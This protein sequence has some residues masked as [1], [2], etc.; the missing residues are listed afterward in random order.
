MVIGLVLLAGMAQAA[1][2][3]ITC[4]NTNPI[5]NSAGGSLAAGYVQIVRS[6]DGAVSL[7]SQATGA[8]LS[9]TDTVISSGTV[10]NGQFSA[11]GI[12]IATGQYVYIV[13]WDTWN[14]VG[15]PSGN[16]GISAISPAMTGVLYTYRPASFRVDDP[17][18]PVLQPDLAVSSNNITV[19]YV[20][21]AANPT[22]TF[23]VRNAG[24]GTMNWTA[25]E[26]TAWITNVNPAS[27]ANAAGVTST[28]TVTIDPAQ[29]N[30]GAVG[31]YAGPI[32]VTGTTAGTLHSPQ[33]VTIT[34][35]IT[36]APNTA[37]NTPT[38]PNPANNA[39]GI[40]A[41]QTLTWTGGDPDAGDTVNYDIVVARDAGLTDVFASTN[42]L[43][44]AS[45]ALTNMDR[46]LYYWR[47]TAEDNHGSRTVGPVWSFRVGNIAAHGILDRFEGTYVGTG[48]DG[49][50]GD[51]NDDYYLMPAGA[52]P[53]LTLS[54]DVPAGAADASSVAI[55]YPESAEEW[56]GYGAIVNEVSNISAYPYI[57][58]WMKGDGSAGTVKFQVRDEDGDNFTV[59]DA[60]AVP[61]SDTSWR[62]YVVNAA[63]L[64]ER[65]G[66]D[67]NGTLDLG[68]I[69]QY[70]FSFSG[71]AASTGT[72]YIDNVE[73]TTELPP[74]TIAVNPAA[75]TFTAEG[76]DP[77]D[78]TLNITNAG[79][80][81][82]VWTISS[83]Q[84][85]LT[86]TP[87]SG[88]NVG[89]V[90]VS[91][92]IT[93]LA[94]GTHNA[95]L[96]IT[97]DGATNSPLTVPVTLTVG[98]APTERMIDDFEGAE[99]TAGAD[100][101]WGEE[102]GDDGYYIDTDPDAAGAALILR[103]VTDDVKSGAHAAGI[104]M[105]AADSAAVVA[106]DWTYRMYGADL[107]A[108]P[109]DI[110][111]YSNIKFNVKGDGSDLKLKVQV[112][113][114][115][116][117]V[118]TMADAAAI[119]L[120]ITVWQEPS[121][122]ISSLVKETSSDGDGTLDTKQIVE[123]QMVFTGLA[124]TSTPGIPTV[125][126]DNIR[127]VNEDK[128]APTIIA[129][130]P[131][132]AAPGDTVT[133]TGSNLGTGGRVEFSADSGTYIAK[134]SDSPIRTWSANEITLVLPTMS[135]GEKEV[136]V[137][138]SANEESNTVILDVLAAAAGSVTY[139]YP[140]PFNPTGGEETTFV[141]SPG[142]AENVGIYI[143]DSTAKLVQKVM[144]TPSTGDA[145]WNGINHSGEIQGDGVYLYRI[146]NEADKSMIGKGK[147]LIINK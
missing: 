147:I 51:G 45:Y 14:G 124:G 87:T 15:V 77:A 25:T 70:Q 60:N 30:G 37:P 28:L 5:L 36:D 7:P 16:Y 98:A 39:A 129:I 9:A 137:V 63:D 2:V 35:N 146:V 139:N 34:L 132:K 40:A 88:T 74:A 24:T 118:F 41:N 122:A 3:T 106:K 47:V 76:A 80:Q 71:S 107:L 144:W 44:A 138:T 116:G 140:N 19:N 48:P 53:T 95:T 29:A 20:R 68:H 69:D 142:D 97:A 12:S 1:V 102:P 100:A 66:A 101:V 46:G 58:F 82:L 10:T 141:F 79:Y 111:G 104:A 11:S 145:T 75:M 114:A 133:I 23:T 64:T 65:I 131:E 13:A 31:S 89:A 105:P 94:E 55:T 32:T 22:T 108:K 120:N 59:A 110:S 123:Y 73:A 18:V 84:D 126:I 112:K 42:D 127:A 130:S 92:S 21:G 134:D 85:W 83:D 6:T 135:N 143:F 52:E 33:T 57:T 62:V 117:D 113:D 90:T 103:Q 115:D 121:V 49:T 136:M 78:Q 125:Y 91:A 93:E 43:T 17:I 4:D 109:V 86:M 119:D 54:T 81:D 38:N 99:V 61:L 128:S 50:L 8:P 27:G 56:R 96:T 67:G 26:A 72:I